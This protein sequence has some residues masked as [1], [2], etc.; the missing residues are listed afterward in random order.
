MR[1]ARCGGPTTGQ[2]ILDNTH[3]YTF[4]CVEWLTVRLAAVEAVAH[5]PVDFGTP[6]DALTARVQQIEQRLA[7][8]VNNPSP[9]GKE[10]E[11]LRIGI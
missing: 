2:D 9:D 6:L 1:C 8:T 3:R 11:R 10:E 4:H 7:S 5:Q